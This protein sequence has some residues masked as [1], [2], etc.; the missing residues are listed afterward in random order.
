MSAPA[1][2]DFS[3]APVTMTD[4]HGGIVLQLEHGAPEFVGGRGVEG[5]ENRRTVDRDDRD[6][7]V[8]IEQEVVKVHG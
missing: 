1:T 4:A 3:P 5:V 2:N 6:G 7:A 8:A